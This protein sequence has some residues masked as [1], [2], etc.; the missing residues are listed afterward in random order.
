[1]LLP[2]LNRF[3]RFAYD[4]ETTGLQVASGAR[5]FGF[6]LST[7]DGEDYYYDIR[8]T[9]AAVDLFN[10]MMADYQGTII[11]HN[12]SF[13]YRMSKATGLYFPLECAIDTCVQ[14]CLINEHE[15]EYSLDHLAKR[16]TK[17]YKKGDQLYKNLA[18]LFGGR[19][20]KTA[21]MDNI[22][23]APP[24]IVAPY[25][26][27]DTR[28]T[29]S[30]ADYQ[31]KEIARQG[32]HKIVAFEKSVTPKLVA[33]EEHGVR[34][35]T[36]AAERAVGE[37]GVVIRDMRK[38]LD[39][40]AGFPCNPTGKGGS[41]KKLF[42]PEW[43]NEKWWAVDGTPLE[44]TPGGAASFNKDAL[45]RMT[46]PAAKLLIELK[47]V[48]RTCDTFLLG[49]VLDSAQGGR[50]YPNV[51]QNRS[52]TGGTR[53]GRLS[54][55]VPALQQIPDRNKKVAQLV[56]QVF[57]PDEGHT[58]VDADMASFEV[59]IFA[60]LVNHPKT[61]DA[62]R[63]NPGMDMH[64][65]VADTM[66]IPRNASYTGEVN[67]KQ[68]NLS[69]M[70]NQGDGT[71][72]D[73]LGLPWEW[74]DFMPKG[75]TLEEDRVYYRKAG[76]EAMAVIDKYH[77]HFPG[78]KNLATECSEEAESLGK[79]ANSYGRHI[80]FPIR[81]LSYKASAVLTQSSAADENKLN[82]LRIDDAIQ[83]TC[84]DAKLLLNT[85]DSYSLSIPMGE[86]EKLARA[87]K[88]RV[89]ADRGLRVPL[90]LEVNRPGKNWWES[91]KA[92]R[93]M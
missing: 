75:K 79:I 82:W 88:E 77:A 55:S 64:Q 56:K 63:K 23:K 38:Q 68:L 42:K 32:L 36:D 12:L 22:S 52:S 15:R 73:K 13:D 91:K 51:N 76:A 78:I 5:V 10:R 33:A 37:L 67:A 1:M 31:T 43:R 81:Y 34:V 7:P 74:V 19:P 62:F 57:V 71:T 21:Q 2:D 11:C 90:I 87:I 50:V 44:E 41:I 9:P 47:E 85:H 20:T 8:E 80:R 30:L 89:E 70:Y 6:S 48:T 39:K 27:G 14:A 53:T 60:H 18:D 59:R 28:S 92:E 83:D 45:M 84:K 3:D 93:W 24:H 49:H 46:H 54:Y 58:W 66:G 26:K 17:D 4:T 40:L 61:L 35:D 65:Y 86:E 16:Y 25:A 72:A 69:M 29:L